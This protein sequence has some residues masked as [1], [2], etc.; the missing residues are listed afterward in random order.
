MH[1]CR[2]SLQSILARGAG[3]AKRATLLKGLAQPLENIGNTWLRNL[4]N[5]FTGTWG[6]KHCGDLQ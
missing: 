1:A 4:G 6:A 3:A 2:L 5:Y